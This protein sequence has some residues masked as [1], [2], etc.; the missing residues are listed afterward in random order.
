MSIFIVD[1]LFH[2]KFNLLRTQYILGSYNE[3]SA[4][5]FARRNK[6][7]VKQFGRTLFGVSVGKV[8]RTTEIELA[9]HAGRLI[10]RGLLSGV[11]GNPAELMILDD[12]IKNRLEADSPVIRRRVWEE[13]QNS[14]KSRLAAGAKVILIMT[15]WHE[16]DLAARLLKSEEN[17][18][19]LRLPVE[20]EEGDLLGRKPGEPLCPELGKGEK[21]LAQFKRS[22]LSDDQGGQRA[23]Q[24]LYQCAPRKEEGNL[25]KR[26]WWRY[27]DPAEAGEFAAEVISVDAAFK[28]GEGNDFVAITVWGKRGN[29]YYL[30]DCR[31]Q[32]LDFS[33]TLA[34]I[35]EMRRRYPGARAVLIEDKANGSA[36]INVLQREMFCIPVNPQGGKAARVNAVTAAIESGHVF[37]PRG[38][39]WLGAYLDQWCAFPAGKHD[40]M[41]DSSTQ[42]LSYLVGRAG[43]RAAGKEEREPFF[44]GGMYAVY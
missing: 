33:G 10:S 41:V 34:A 20:A 27:Y 8:D 3:T 7:K 18:T 36:V 24:A 26:G 38:A 13:W 23:W 43:V 1:L 31:N 12:P 16:D 28:G 37:L 21:W 15:P 17:I 44:D 35:R 2:I 9:G 32:H 5:R 40:D 30:R 39:A 6:E 14:F 4:E 29:D 25:V 22:Y 11:T 42:A 19:L